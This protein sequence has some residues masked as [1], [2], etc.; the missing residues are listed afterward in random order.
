MTD[1]KLTEYYSNNERAV[2]VTASF[3]WDQP[4]LLYG[5][6]VEYDVY[7]SDG[8]ALTGN[9]DLNTDVN[10]VSIIILTSYICK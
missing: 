5:S 4:V 1:K 2:S 9:E 6:L 7:L 8:K 10:T 3:M